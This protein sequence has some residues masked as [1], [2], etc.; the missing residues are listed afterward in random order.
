MDHEQSADRRI[1]V[2]GLTGGIGAG[3]SAVA[4]ILAKM[5]CVISNSDAE[6]RAA[7]RDPVIRDTLVSWWGDEVL[8]DAGEIDRR[9]V[10][11]IVF[12]D[13]TQRKRL[14]SLT[15]P[16][17][18]ARRDG[19]FAAAS[20][21][22]PA[23]VIDAPLLLEVGLDRECDAVLFVDAPDAV[24]LK[25]LEQHRGWDESELRAREESQL[26]LDEKRKRA[27]HVIR[28]E[29]DLSELSAQVRSILHTILNSRPA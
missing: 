12:H 8:D 26:P 24:R 10:A 5:G 19:L 2:L 1:P 25:R 11:D 22:T 13:A 4:A 9:V 7:L 28:N 6:G 14:E 27:D 23:L 17:I 29:G 3:K 15:H 18:R 21:D 20:P 16:W